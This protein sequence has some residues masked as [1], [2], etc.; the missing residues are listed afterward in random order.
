M[1]IRMC[2]T[3]RCAE[4]F[5][6]CVYIVLERW[7]QNSECVEFSSYPTVPSA[8]YHEH[9][10]YL[11]LTELRIQTDQK[12]ANN[13]IDYINPFIHICPF[14]QLP[15]SSYWKRTLQSPNNKPIL[16]TYTHTLYSMPVSIEFHLI[17]EEFEMQRPIHHHSQWFGFSLSY[18]VVSSMRNHI[19]IHLLNFKEFQQR[20]KIHAA[21][22][23]HHWGKC[24]CVCTAC[25]QYGTLGKWLGQINQRFWDMITSKIKA[26]KYSKLE[27]PP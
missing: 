22:R 2:V 9:W 14:N 26:L 8:Y 3:T 17:S 27:E 21:E 4:E 12:S 16:T 1:Q 5:T 13:E 6:A 20:L 7:S 25:I 11:F 24:V 19:I 15:K 10:T 23:Y 18:P